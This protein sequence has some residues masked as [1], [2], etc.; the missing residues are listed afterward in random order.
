MHLHMY[1]HMYRS[2]APALTECRVVARRWAHT[3]WGGTVGFSYLTAS[4]SANNS[5]VMVPVN[6]IKRMQERR[7]GV[8]GEGDAQANPLIPW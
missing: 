1:L 3:R 4:K 8:S 5:F 6:R 2:L 7:K